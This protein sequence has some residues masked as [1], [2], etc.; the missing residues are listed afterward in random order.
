[1]TDNKSFSNEES[2]LISDYMKI[3]PKS[4]DSYTR[5]CNC[6][7]NGNTRRALF[8]NPYPVYIS[9]GEG[10]K[11]YDIDGNEYLDY[12]NNLGSIILGHNHPELLDVIKEQLNKGT[13]LG[14]P[15][16]LEIE[17]AEGILEAFPHG[18]NVL[19][20]ATGTEANMIALR[21]VRAYTGKKTILR[22]E[23]S[24]HGTANDF[25]E[26]P[27]IPEE[28]LANSIKVPFNDI[29][30][31]ENA[32]MNHKEKLAAV[33]IEPVFRGIPPKPGY[34]NKI[35]E[36]TSNNNILLVFDEVV[37]G[38]RVG[39]GGAQEK[40]NVKA[41]VTL[42]G[43]IIGGGFPVGAVVASRDILKLFRSKQSTS[44]VVERPPLAHAGTWN[45]HPLVM[46]A[47]LAVLRE[48]GQ[49]EYNHLDNMGNLLRK[50]IEDVFDKIGLKS[51]VYG[52]GSI[53][54]TCFTNNEIVDS[55]S[56]KTSIEYLQR[57]FDLSLLLKNIYPA[58]AHFSFISTPTKKGD[59][60]YTLEVMEETL[61]SMMPIIK[62]NYPF[63]VK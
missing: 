34:L 46:A 28:V 33:Y 8:Y 25:M 2:R 21:A 20:C 32:I 16:E 57:Y 54:H 48:L 39:R 44:L 38:F 1:M 45:A 11:V 60:E 29:D 9:R 50:G 17:L 26:G 56:A 10:C 27:G 59:I 4:K 37:T 35:R 19:Y 13:V 62:E 7:P 41:D 55:E 15:T 47:G 36:I 58:K 52:I 30:S 12:A 40:Y 51:R 43:K 22:I 42:L 6:I 5:A 61:N 23:G 14:G 24:F 18:E 63:L 31:F 53:F 49:N 3:T